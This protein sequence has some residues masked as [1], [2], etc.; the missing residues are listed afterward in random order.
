MAIEL[1]EKGI[2]ACVIYP[3]VVS[4]EFI[5]VAAERQRINLSQAQTPLLVG[6][7]VVALLMSDSMMSRTGTIQ[8]VKNLVDEFDLYDEDGFR[9]E[10]GSVRRE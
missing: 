8:W 4:T 9:P 7:A 2:P 6:R 5:K 1:K 3:G 10:K